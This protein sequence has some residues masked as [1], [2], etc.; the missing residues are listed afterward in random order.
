MYPIIWEELQI[1]KCVLHRN[2][3]FF[4]KAIKHTV[5]VVYFW[6]N[7]QDPLFID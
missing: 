1:R 6:D 4:Y 2:Y 7:R 3:S 5:V